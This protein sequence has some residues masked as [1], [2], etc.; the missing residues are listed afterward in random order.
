MGTTTSPHSIAPQVRQWTLGRSLDELDSAVHPL[1]I[2]TN[3]THHP[4]RSMG[5]CVSRARAARQRA[6]SDRAATL[7]P[8]LTPPWRPSAR[9][10]GSPPAR[11][12]VAAR[13][14][15]RQEPDSD[16]PT[17]LLPPWT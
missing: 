13:S 12:L 9:P 10:G 8:R 1:A 17:A 11:T 5:A 3:P 7:A 14:R 4:H 16:G 6:K 15:G 2:S